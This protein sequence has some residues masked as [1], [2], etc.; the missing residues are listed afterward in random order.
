MKR[1]TNPS[2]DFP[3][4]LRS[5]RTI[6]PGETVEV[7]DEEFDTAGPF[8]LRETDERESPRRERKTV[9]RSAHRE[10]ETTSLGGAET[11]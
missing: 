10:I 11:R 9:R 7:T 4:R 1:L 3:I 5:G 6:A 8:L 2:D